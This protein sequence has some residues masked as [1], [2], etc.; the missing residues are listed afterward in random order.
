MS[1]ISYETDFS[2]TLFPIT[3]ADPGFPIGGGGRRPIG[4]RGANL[5][6]VHFSAK[7]YVK[8]KEMDPVGGGARAGGAPP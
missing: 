8:M 7:M 6:D 1:S 3:V 5:Q 2:N 4:G